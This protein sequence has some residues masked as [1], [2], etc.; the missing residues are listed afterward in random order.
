MDGPFLS[1]KWGLPLILSLGMG[2]LGT[3]TAL[4]IRRAKGQ[5][6]DLLFMLAVCWIPFM[7]GCLALLMSLV[8]SPS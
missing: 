7:V 2:C 6:K 8:G 3:R 1:L 4:H 5:R